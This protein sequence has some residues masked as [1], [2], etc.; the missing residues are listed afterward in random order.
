MTHLLKMLA[1]PFAFVTAFMLF[2][3]PA[4]PATELVADSGVACA[5]TGGMCYGG[6]GPDGCCDGYVS[7]PSGGCIPSHCPGKQRGANL[8][9]AYAAGLGAIAIGASVSG[10]PA[11]LALGAF[12]GALSLGAAGLT[13]YIRSHQN[14]ECFGG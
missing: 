5:D 9:D 14:P 1:V 2:G 12:A 6:H 4:A 10:G 13:W 11:G 7:T 8:G 3:T